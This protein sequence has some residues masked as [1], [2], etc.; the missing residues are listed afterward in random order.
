MAGD[1]TGITKSDGARDRW[2]LTYTEHCRLT[3]KTYSMYDVTV[4]DPEYWT[5]DYHKD[6]SKLRIVRDENDVKKL[7]EQLQ[8][9]RTFIITARTLYVFSKKFISLTSP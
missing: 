3:Q 9:F 5:L 6:I 4:D 2:C 1:L 8:H 7:V